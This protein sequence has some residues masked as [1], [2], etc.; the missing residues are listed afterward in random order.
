MDVK[1]KATDPGSIRFTATLT[2]P[3]DQWM[4]LR[5]SLPKKHP[6]YELSIAISRCVQDAN[7]TFMPEEE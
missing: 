7:A 1:I 5:E 4:E 3:L 6:W 2:L